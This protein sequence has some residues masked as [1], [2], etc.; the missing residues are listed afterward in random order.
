MTAAQETPTPRILV[1]DDDPAVVDWLCEMLGDK[2]WRATGETQSA[3]ALERI[4]T[5]DFDVV[6]SDIEMPELRGPELMRA[7]FAARPRQL[8]ILITAFGSIELAVESLKAGAVDFLAKPFSVEALFHAIERALSER[9]MRREIVRLRAELSRTSDGIVARSPAMKRALAMARRAAESDATVLLRGESG[10]GKGALA[11]FIHQTGR[12]KAGPFVDLNCAAIP[13]TL[14]E[15]ELFGAKRGA[16]T[17]AKVDR[18]GL[19]VRAQGGTVFLDEIGD[20]PLEVQPKLLHALENGRVRPVGGTRDAPIDVRVIA[21]T[22]QPLEEAMHERRFRSDLY[23]RLAVIGIDIP[24]LRDRREDI[25]P[26]AEVFLERACARVGRPV[27]GIAASGIRWMLAHAWPG[28]VRELANA[29]ERAVAL[30]EHDAL[31]V[32][33]LA[34]PPTSSAR[35]SPVA[36]DDAASLALVE[37]QHIERVLS[38]VGG[39]KT[40][41]ARILGIDRRTLYRKLG[42][43]LDALD[44]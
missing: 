32:E 35:P 44:K 24:P 7:I 41:A 1:V 18:D 2:G 17:D 31:V 22:N 8:V 34:P 4:R 5:S 30:T 14:V 36:S 39:N 15:S 28:N 26:L 42:E 3:R 43:P 19:F 38:A 12:R 21:A 23:Y 20:M 29:I 16:F 27:S 40:K 37:Q 11:R 9:S 25:E 13:A 33:D 10:V 6:V